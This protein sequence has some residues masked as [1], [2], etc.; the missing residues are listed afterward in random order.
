ME[1]GI[2]GWMECV[3]V[4]II[5][6]ILHSRGDSVIAGWK[7]CATVNIIWNVLHSKWTVILQVE[8]SVL[9]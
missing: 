2:S 6:N 3:T 1:S 9:E 5:R 7:E 4:N 8:W